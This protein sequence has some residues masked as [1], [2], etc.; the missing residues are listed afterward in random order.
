MD[1]TLNDR[2]WAAL[3]APRSIALVG[4]SERITGVSFT[5]RFLANNEQLAFPGEIHLINPN[6]ATI[7]GRPCHASLTALTRERGAP[8]CVIVVLPEDKV[9]PAVEE[10]IACGA[11]ALMIH[12]GGFLE[13]GA[14]G[15]ERQERITA[16][17]RAAGVALIGPNCLGFVG[18]ASQVALYGSPLPPALPA[19]PIAA[20]T[21]SGSVASTFFQLGAQFGMSFLA[22]TGNE[23]VT[24]SEELL[25]R[26]V[27]DRSTELVVM[28]LET[29]RDP[30][31]FIRAA[32]AARR[33]GK[34][35]IA[36]KVGLTERGGL[37]SRG[38]TGAIA[39][40]GA[41]YRQAFDQQG[42]ILAEDFDELEQTV[43]LFMRLR[44]KPVGPRIAILGTSG[45]KLGSATDSAVELGLA[46]AHPSAE[47]VARLQEV[48]CLPAST[49]PRLPLDVGIGFRSPAA[50][51][52]R[53]RACMRVLDQDPGVDVL[54]VLHDLEVPDDNAPSLNGE[55]VRAVAAEAG[56][57][58]K[59]V[60]VFSSHSGRASRKLL[61]EVTAQG[62]AV[63]EGA[64]PS[65]RALWH[66]TRPR[67][68]APALTPAASDP[69]RVQHWLREQAAGAC[70]LDDVMALLA[71]QG[72]PVAPLHAIASP[73]QAR[74]RLLQIG[75]RA[76]M[77][78]DAPDLIHK[79]D[80][81]GVVLGIVTLDEAVAA[82]RKLGAH[83]A[84]RGG[85]GRVLMGAQLDAG[86]E[87]YV[88]AKWDAAFGAT[89]VFGLGGRLVEVL[90]KTALAI[91][92]LDKAAALDL[93]ERS[94]A[95]K[96]LAGYRGG[97][98]ADL[99][100]LAEAIVRVGQLAQALGDRLEALDLNPIIV[101]PAHPAG[102]A[103][104]ARLLLR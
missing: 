86:T 82:W 96:L 52:D 95:R 94:G 97:P 20:I 61:T 87:V 45:G 28:F 66:L 36:L 39:G 69:G 42:V 23:A 67:R 77:K 47:T 34:Q 80:S 24:S 81:G 76:V 29:L 68:P 43:R 62:L 9:V 31:R 83:P 90:G 15:Q 70:R 33:A 3:T 8:D 32:Q 27:A 93:V 85:Q 103:V 74:E 30:P 46:L 50:Y 2:N 72:I 12:S 14:E 53:F 38:H 56:S 91:A 59:P 104:D 11:R 78:V 84:C 16:L 98:E 17:C 100:A 4:A 55:I 5:N 92:P 64:R 63:L 102:C 60:L 22:S 73:E 18:V 41:V 35:I 71:G 101:N 54:A 44:R 99:D 37:V 79:S 21:Q 10:A 1:G 75:G 65:L 13:A 26:A 89:I 7:F 51:G 19:G 6:R 58:Q 48:L 49:V 88:G 57:L 40:D 25:E